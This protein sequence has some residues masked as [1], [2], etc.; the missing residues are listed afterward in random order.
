MLNAQ[1]AFPAAA[2]RRLMLPAEPG[3]PLT[4]R[5]KQDFEWT[6]NGRTYVYVDPA[7][8]HV[9]ATEDPAS[10]DTASAIAEK[11]YPVHSGKVGGLF[12]HLALTF[13]GLTLALLGSLAAWSF[14]FATSSRPQLRPASAEHLGEPAEQRGR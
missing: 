14:W 3:A 13:S 2:P 5:L 8:G 7:T 1:A 9:L 10:G 12:W 6:P 4:L 11:F